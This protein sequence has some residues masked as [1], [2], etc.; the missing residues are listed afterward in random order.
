MEAVTTTPGEPWELTYDDMPD[1]EFVDGLRLSTDCVCCRLIAPLDPDRF[2]DFPEVLGNRGHGFERILQE[3][4]LRRYGVV[5]HREIVVPWQFGESHLDLWMPKPEP[6]FDTGGRALQLE[7]KA[8]KDAQVKTENVRQVHRQLYAVELAADAGRMLRMRVRGEDGAWRWQRVDPS[9]LLEAQWR[10]A[11]ID[12]TTWR[13]PDPR[14]V[15]VKLSDERRAE[16]AVEWQQMRDFM[17]LPVN[18]MRWNIEIP[19]RMPKCTCGKAFRPELRELDEECAEHASVYLEAQQE[20]SF[21]CDE[22]ELQRDWL[23]GRLGKNLPADEGAPFVGHG[24]AVTVSKP[25][26]KGTRSVRVR[27]S[28]AKAA[29]QI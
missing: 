7:L 4:L 18:T 28:Q 9:A 27:R 10:I 17:A 26:A 29:P 1:E 15:Q 5:A 2:H 13:I 19:E 14:G 21:A 24:F 23:L 20:A 6:A 11:V 8:N 12:P 22:Q 16:L 3:W 25:N